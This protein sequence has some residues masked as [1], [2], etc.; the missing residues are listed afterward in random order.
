MGASPNW[1]SQYLPTQPDATAAPVPGPTASTPLAGNV[2]KSD[3]IGML[4]D[5]MTGRG[6]FQPGTGSP[7]A[8]FL[9]G[10]NPLPQ[11]LHS[12][13]ALHAGHPGQ[14][15]MIA[16][17]AMLPA[18]VPEAKPL[19]G[20]LSAGESS[21]LPGALEAMANRAPIRATPELLKMVERPP[22]GPPISANLMDGLDP[23]M[24]ARRAP[25]TANQVLSA[26]ERKKFS[27]AFT[28]HILRPKP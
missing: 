27:E 19:E 11:A 16:G 24:F 8:S 10:L 4:P 17:M 22:V 28:A 14:A 21:A 2:A 3:P 6:A 26:A 20:L 9:K 1:L 18:A 12:V 23:S 5:V 13:Q 15:A 7:I 25:P